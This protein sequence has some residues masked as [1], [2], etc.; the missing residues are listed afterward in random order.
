M[1]RPLHPD[2]GA[3]LGRPLAQTLRDR[4]PRLGDHQQAP[5]GPAGPD[6]LLDVRDTERPSAD[7]AG[8]ELRQAMAVAERAQAALARAGP[9]PAH[10]F[11][12]A[13]RDRAA[14]LLTAE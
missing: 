10:E 9:P 14:A 2:L 13:G 7:T 8:F 1:D 5:A 12:A 3:I 6:F 11:T 4:G